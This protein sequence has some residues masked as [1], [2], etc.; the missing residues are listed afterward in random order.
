MSSIYTY[1]AEDHPDW[2]GDIGLGLRASTIIANRFILQAEDLPVYSFYLENEDLRTWS[3]RFGATAYSHA[4]PFNIKAGFKRNDL[5]QRPQLE[6]SRPYQYSSSEWSA[7]VDIGRQRDLFLTAYMSLNRM[8]F[9]DDPY[10]G[11]Y[12][13]ADRLNHRET[14][15]GVRLNKRVFTGTFVYANFERIN[16]NFER[17]GERDTK[18]HQAAVGV[19]FPEMGALQGS[20]QIGIRRFEPGN[21][22][23]RNV[24]RANGRGNVSL[25][26]AERVKL[27]G[28]YELGT[29]F[30]YFSSD[31]FYDS[32]TL[33]GGVDLYLTRFLKVGGT[34]SDGRLKYR[35]FI[36]LELLRNDRVRQQSYYLAFPFIGN[37][38]LG[39]SYNVYRLT[40][41]ALS[42]DYTRD[43]WGGFLSY[44]F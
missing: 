44:G 11:E 41:D 10:W 25:T 4:G 38:S 2:T 31:Q 28:S 30:S 29:L 27:N 3:N 21:P 19:R 32:N 26:L 35:S 23:F 14:T 40:S 5:F 17:S 43:Y 34:Y 18:A 39:F 37:T 36:D 1:D 24:Q 42:L 16:F 33:G 6:F 12:N 20:F 13:L 7:A 15:L 22:L 8:D 9:D